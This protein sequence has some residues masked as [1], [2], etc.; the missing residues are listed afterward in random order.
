MCRGFVFPQDC[1][2]GTY[3]HRVCLIIAKIRFDVSEMNWLWA[4]DS[5]RYGPGLMMSDVTGME[6]GFP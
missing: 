3:C 6:T 5:V 1:F 2:T 4:G